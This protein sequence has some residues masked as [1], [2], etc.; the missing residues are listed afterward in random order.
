MCLDNCHR[1]IIPDNKDYTEAVTSGLITETGSIE[2]S[3]LTVP[4]AYGFDLVRVSEIIQG[5]SSN[6]CPIP[7]FRK[8]GLYI[9]PYENHSISIVDDQVDM[10]SH[11][12]PPVRG[13]FGRI[14][15]TVFNELA[16]TENDTQTLERQE[17]VAEP[18][19][20]Q[21][22]DS[23]EPR[24]VSELRQVLRTSS[25]FIHE[26]ANSSEQTE[27]IHT[28]AQKK[29]TVKAPLPPEAAHKFVQLMLEREDVKDVALAVPPKQDNAKKR[30]RGV[31]TPREDLAA[32]IFNEDR[33]SH[34]HGWVEL[35]TGEKKS[36]YV[37]HYQP[38]MLDVD[39]KEGSQ[40]D[41]LAFWIELRPSAKGGIS[42][43]HSEKVDW[44][45]V[46]NSP[47]LNRGK[48]GTNTSDNGD[49]AVP[50]FFVCDRAKLCEY[51]YTKLPE[52]GTTTNNPFESVYKMYREGRKLQLKTRM[53]FNDLLS[54]KL[55]ELRA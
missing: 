21:T 13:V 55:I 7:N 52:K 27:T 2:A 41:E 49:N 15:T 28:K 40:Y 36:F 20:R 34:I 31:S 5:T 54:E 16:E 37:S 22:I 33:L 51:L 35:Q 8:L 47:V 38:L 25:S 9:N 42:A 53:P 19:N 12:K 44:F 29:K 18:N 17:T 23:R 6:P 24:T 4:P 3:Q 50:K 26:S 46:E 39:V 10:A 32:D 48:V 43:I 30:K 11:K 1:N 14:N 45:V